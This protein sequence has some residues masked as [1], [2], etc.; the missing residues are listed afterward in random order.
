[1]ARG[2]LITIYDLEVWL[3][4]SSCDL[5]IWKCDWRR[6]LVTFSVFVQ[7]AVTNICQATNKQLF[8][9]VEWAKHI[10]HFTSLP[11]GDQVLLLRAGNTHHSL[12][13][14]LCS[15]LCN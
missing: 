12:K 1:V 5:C 7:S 6:S 14:V 13:T 15:C 4:E 3:V 10:P 11:L 2:D 8:Q 9:L